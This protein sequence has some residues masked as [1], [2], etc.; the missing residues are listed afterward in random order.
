MGADAAPLAFPTLGD[1]E[2]TLPGKVGKKCQLLF[3]DR[4]NFWVAQQLPKWPHLMTVPSPPRGFSDCLGKTSECLADIGGAAEAGNAV[5][6]LTL[7]T[8]FQMQ[9]RGMGFLLLP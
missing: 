7:R 9:Q 6:Q 4:R 1:F 8:P 3:K 2:E 5:D